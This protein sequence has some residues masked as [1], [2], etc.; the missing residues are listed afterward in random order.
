MV[1]FFFFPKVEKS[2]NKLLAETLIVIL[3][4]LFGLATTS[5]QFFI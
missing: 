5:S 3:A 1:I 4:V 2:K